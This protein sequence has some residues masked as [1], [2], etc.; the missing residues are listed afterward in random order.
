VIRATIKKYVLHPGWIRSVID[1]QKHYISAHQLASLYRVS[2]AECVIFDN[3]SSSEEVYK[4]YG[5]I[6]L[7]P[8]YMGNYNV[9]YKD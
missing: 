8:N 2:M 6:P 3:S 5:L 7:Y 4:N 9:P 1:G